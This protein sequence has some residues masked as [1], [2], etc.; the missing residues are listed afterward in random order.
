MTNNLPPGVVRYRG[1]TLVEITVV[2]TILLTLTSVL[3]IG[4]R[5]L[6]IGSD[7][8]GCVLTLR[9]LQFVVRSYQNT[10]GN[11]YGTQPHAENGTQDIA[12]QLFAKGYIE[13]K[14]FR[15]SRGAAS[16][17]VAGIYTC[18]L[19][20]VFPQA[21]EL[22]MQCSRAVSDDHQPTSFGEW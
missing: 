20:D 19:P 14:L 6:K 10:R 9:N 3:F 21:G 7:R 22:Y 15:Q 2:F 16:C 5:A 4:S 17:P 11:N 13:V 12:E 1:L 18:P 8:A